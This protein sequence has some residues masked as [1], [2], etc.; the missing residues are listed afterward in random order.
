VVEDERGVR[1]LVCNTLAAKGYKVLEAHSSLDAA[2]I[3]GSYGEPIHLLLTDVVMPQMSGKVLA[4]HMAALH[5]E[6]RVLYM[7]GYTDDAIVR[8][9]IQEPNSFLLP[10]P[11]SPSG[12]LQKVREVLDAAPPGGPKESPWS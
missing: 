5:P 12:L 4:N 8:H 2:S 1:S 7:S 6:T 9:G 11:F 10:K 3:M